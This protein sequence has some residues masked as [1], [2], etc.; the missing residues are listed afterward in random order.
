MN[1]DTQLGPRQQVILTGVLRDLRG[2]L[3]SFINSRDVNNSATGEDVSRPCRRDRERQ[4]RRVRAAR[5]GLAELNLW[6]WLG[7]TP[8]NVDR[9]LCHR[10]LLR[11]ESMGLLKRQAGRSGR[12]TTHVKLT[13]PGLR[14]AR[15]LL[16][17]QNALAAEADELFDGDLPMQPFDWPLEPQADTTAP[18]SSPLNPPPAQGEPGDDTVKQPCPPDAGHETERN[19]YED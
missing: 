11:L 16:A 15:R 1:F 18:A 10:E 9:V 17:E 14:A 4:F 19:F 2:I 6:R 3:R 7:R 5:E 12:R 13:A 8:S